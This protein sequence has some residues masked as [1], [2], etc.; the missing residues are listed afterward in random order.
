MAV[1]ALAGVAAGQQPAGQDAPLTDAQRA[2]RLKQTIDA[3]EKQLEQLRAQVANPESEFAKAEADFLRLDQELQAKQRALQKLHDEPGEQPEEATLQTALNA[4]RKRWQLA[5]DRFDLAFKERGTTNQQIATLEQ[6][7]AADKTAYDRLTAPVATQPAAAQATTTQ[8]A[9]AAAAPVATQ[10]APAA[11][12]DAS[13]GT[14][15]LSPTG[16]PVVEPNKPAAAEANKPVSPE[17]AKAQEEAAAAA[18]EATIAQEAVSTIDNRIA[19]ERATIAQASD[20]RRTFRKQAQNARKTVSTLNEQLEQLQ[21]QAAQA[22]DIEKRRELFRQ[23]NELRAQRDDARARE[24]EAMQKEQA[25]LDKIEAANS[26]LAEL[27]SERIATLREAAEKER[28]AAAAQKLVDEIRNPFSPEN[29]KRWLLTSGTTILG[30]IL[31]AAFLLW[32]TRVISHRIVAIVVSRAEEEKAVERE[33][34][35][36]TLVQVFNNAAYIAILAAGLL[37]LLPELGVDVVP[38]VGGV[39]VIGLAVAFGAQNLVRDFFT[40]FMILLENQYGINDVVK[41]GDTAGLVERITLR[42]TVLRGLDGTVHFVPN[43]QITTVSNM[44]HGWSRALFDIGVAYKEDVDRVMKILVELGKELREDIA[45]R[46][47]ILDDPEMLGVDAFADS[48]IVVRFFIK[49]KPLQQWTVKRALLRR[50][51]KRFDAEGIEIPFPHRTVF[52]RYEGGDG[53]PGLE[54]IGE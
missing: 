26:R 38:L 35:M 8:P 44:T 24:T 16:V 45:F 2:A 15:A 51:K 46:H 6:K 5:K 25:E 36:R 33:N 18:Q 30:I 43:G 34:R 41:L 11:A 28:E 3:T 31:G 39:A 19:A 54:A 4:L 52:H 21:E 47:L 13:G 1:V 27:Q 37:L 7:L 17:L 20:L 23:R 40:G 22:K 50:I 10:P 49:T 53:K 32:L 48:A 12:G 29:I 14:V 42:I 9:S